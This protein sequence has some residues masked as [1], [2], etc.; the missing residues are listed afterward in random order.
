[1]INRVWNVDE[2]ALWTSTR[3][4]RYRST[5]FFANIMIH[6]W[7]VSV[8]PGLCQ[9]V[10]ADAV[11]I[12]MTWFT[13]SPWHKSVSC[14][15]VNPFP[16]WC[17]D[18]VVKSNPNKNVTCYGNTPITKQQCGNLRMRISHKNADRYLVGVEISSRD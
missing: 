1:M 10:H 2:I 16:I 4:L 3:C 13:S 7:T 18:F 8:P 11:M 14:T 12:D 9:Q 5:L 17:S 15:S 6:C